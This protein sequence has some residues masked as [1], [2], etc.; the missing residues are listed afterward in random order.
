MQARAPSRLSNLES[1]VVSKQQ[2]IAK[3]FKRIAA[4]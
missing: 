3:A 2:A 4:H 1:H